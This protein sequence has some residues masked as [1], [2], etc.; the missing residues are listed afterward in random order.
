VHSETFRTAIAAGCILG[1]VF[2]H[3]SGTIMLTLGVFI[4]LLLAAGAGFMR[5]TGWML[6]AAPIPWLVGV[7]G[8][9]LVGQ[10]DSIGEFWFVPFLL[11][12]IAGAI[13][14]TFGVAA[15][16]GNTRSK[17]EQND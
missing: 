5:P 14:V 17:L 15:R 4:W 8:G 10:H 12:T 7:A 2:I 13:G 11:S 6:L 16:K 1:G 3:Y 9:A